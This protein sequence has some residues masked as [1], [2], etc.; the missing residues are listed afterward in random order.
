MGWVWSERRYDDE[1]EQG[2][3]RDRPGLTALFTDIAAGLVDCVVV[4]RLDRLSRSTLDST[5]ILREFCDRNVA[6]AIVTAPELGNSAQDM[7]VLNILSSFAEFEQDMIRERMS[8]AR[9]AHKR[10]GLR[11]TGIVLFG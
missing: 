9:V 1:A 10:R 8:E 7:F 6:L 5:T 3:R 2:D 11:V 4:H